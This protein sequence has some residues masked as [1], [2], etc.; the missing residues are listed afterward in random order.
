MFYMY[1]C[2]GHLL[3]F[4]A[5]IELCFLREFS[6]LLSSW[7]SCQGLWLALGRVLQAW[8]ALRRD[9]DPSFLAAALRWLII[10]TRKG[11]DTA[12]GL[13]DGGLTSGHLTT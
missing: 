12:A 6:R 7:G 5:G 8:V 1:S 13:R 9:G 3:P 2:H 10:G 4:S 11:R